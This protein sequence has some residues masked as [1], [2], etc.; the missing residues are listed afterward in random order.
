MTL[1]V[2]FY[3]YHFVRTIL[4]NT[5]LS[6]YHFVRYHF[7]LE[8]IFLVKNNKITSYMR[9]TNP[10]N[11]TATEEP[12][13]IS[14]PIADPTFAVKFFGCDSELK[15]VFLTTKLTLNNSKLGSNRLSR[16]FSKDFGSG[17]R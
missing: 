6:V 13:F 7:V 5:I 1:Y 9:H 12:N 10:A 17:W 11:P 8:P 14:A 4:S 3:L 16:C 15:F 2:I